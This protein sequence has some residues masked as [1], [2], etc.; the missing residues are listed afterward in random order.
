MP[1]IRVKQPSGV[2]A[3]KYDST[4]KLYYL[5]IDSVRVAQIDSSG[6]MAVKGQFMEASL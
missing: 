4:N 3:W 6:N 5:L 1:K 2:A